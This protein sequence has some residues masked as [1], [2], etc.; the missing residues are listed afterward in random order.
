MKK[1]L[2][3]DDE[4]LVIKAI[5]DKLTNAQFATDSALDGQR[6]SCQNKPRKARPNT[7]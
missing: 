5:R 2:I 3:V 4:P 7:S 1:I 6:S